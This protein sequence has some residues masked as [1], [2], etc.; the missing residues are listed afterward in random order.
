MKIFWKGFCGIIFQTVLLREFF[1][2]FYG[3]E[4][5]FVFTLSLWII[6]AA[7]GSYFLRKI[8]NYPLTYNF[9]TIFENFFFIISI[10]LLRGTRHISQI[11]FSQS[12][13]LFSFLIV[14]FAGFIEGG[15]FVL[16]SSLYRWE[17]SS[18]R[19]Y[20]LESVGALTGGVLLPFFFSLNLNTFHIL[21]LTSIFNF[22]T[23]LEFKKHKFSFLFLFFLFF[24]FSFFSPFI[25]T[26][27]LNLK[28]KPF[29]IIK[30]FY[31]PYQNIEIVRKNTEIVLSSN[32]LPEISNQPDYYSLKNIV[33]FSVCFLN[34][35]KNAIIVSS[36]E[37]IEEIMKY[38]PEKI[39]YV[40][41]DKKKIEIV[42][43]YFLKKNYKNLIFIKKDPYLF[44]KNTDLNF[45]VIFIGK[46]LPLSFREN[47]KFTDEFV[48]L[49]SRKVKIVSLILPGNYD[50]I[51]KDT[52][53]LHSIIYHTF[54]KHFRYSKFIFSY[55][56][57][58]IYSNIPL[59]NVNKKMIVD[60]DF[61][62]RS[63]LKYVLDKKR[64]KIYIAKNIEKTPLNTLNSQNLF[65]FSIS[66]FFSF[67]NKK[68]GVFF[69]DYFKKIT[70][71]KI[72][73]FIFSFIF[74]I[75]FL[76]ISKKNIRSGIIFTNGFVCFGYE[77]LLIIITQI[78]HGYIY[79]KISTVIALF[80]GGISA[81][82]IISGNFLKRKHLI[83]SELLNFSFYSISFLLI[84]LLKTM[85]FLLL[86]ILI[87]ISGF[88]VGFEFGI[89]SG[90]EKG[91]FTDK[92]GKLY[93]FDLTGGALSSIS[94]PLLILPIFGLYLSFLIF[95][96]VKFTNLIFQKPWS[97]ERINSI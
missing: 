29:K 83:Y 63:Y 74:F 56:F 5:S 28:W 66:H 17:K 47:R 33:F 40:G 80:M 42:K 10:F 94:I 13:L 2:V 49:V 72:L 11:Q 21:F 55:P 12:F 60:N 59:N 65:F 88:F 93:A 46:C 41:Q 43:K 91:G 87:F 16:L 4:L 75:I 14:F 84:Y 7:E 90:I 31:T 32:G 61:F 58:S 64:A 39:Y 89:I 68:A 20:G 86:I 79:S 44:L 36:P 23:L 50:Y 96:L 19:I 76:F 97:W 51:G 37:I 30:S 6:A 8:R 54:K 81:G 15:K 48:S 25:E 62:N 52:S 92:T 53:F 95:P 69:F 1:S 73:P 24:L 71:T 34:K 77:S 57:I 26:K 27:S 3:T 18:G 78:I 45:D 82:A 67:S 38:R 70:R 9:L 35:F 85:P 22:L